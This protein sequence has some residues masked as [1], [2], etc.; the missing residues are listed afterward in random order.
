MTSSTSL[1]IHVPFCQSK[2]AYC[3]FFSLVTSPMELEDYVVNLCRH[4]DSL[5]LSQPSDIVV[6]TVFLGGGT[7]SLLEPSQLGRI[8]EA[9]GRLG[10][11]PAD[12]EIS[13]E[14]NPGTLSLEKLQGYRAAGVNR[15]SLGV[16][17]L[18]DRRLRWLGRGHDRSE[19]LGAVDLV[20]RAGFENLSL[21]FIF[22]QPGQDAAQIEDEVHQYLSLGPE[23]LS[24]Y[25]LS[26]EEGTPLWERRERGA[27]ELPGEEAYAQQYLLLSHLLKAGGYGHYEISNFARPGFECRHNLG[28][29]H[30]RNCL[31]VG[32]GAHSFLE[33]GWGERLEV[34]P[35]LAAYA[36]S[37]EAGVDPAYSLEVFGR[38][39]A[40]S[41]TLYLGLRTEQGVCK[42][43]FARRFGIGLDEV[44]GGEARGLA[45]YL[46]CDEE[47]WHFSPEGWL[48]YDHLI[49]AFL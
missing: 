42:Q 21:D 29:W 16:Q 2:C 49:S 28:Y 37:L 36:R 14:A 38:K 12:V 33:R 24:L 27:F 48:L 46:R 26:V 41:E 23:H 1:Y 9:A 45:T 10:T 34:A 40:M 17:S 8:L 31:A 43:D 39:G 18:C 6:K 7:P 44:F 35:D 25:G 15:M 20:R 13:M 11:F 4:L 30:R 22:A 5:A 47:R 19:A 3:D 32:A